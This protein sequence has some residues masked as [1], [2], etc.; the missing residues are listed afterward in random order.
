MSSFSLHRLHA[1]GAGRDHDEIVGRLAGAE[2]DRAGSADPRL[3]D[4]RAAVPAGTGVC[5]H[6]L[7]LGYPGRAAVRPAQLPA[8]MRPDPE[9]TGG[10]VAPAGE[11]R[12][13]LAGACRAVAGDFGRSLA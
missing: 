6:E 5:H 9:V 10:E 8:G 7:A 11:C 4:A 1:P 13:D 2:P 12:D 3:V